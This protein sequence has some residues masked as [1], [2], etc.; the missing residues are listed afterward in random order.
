M[1]IT[2]KRIINKTKKQEITEKIQMTNECMEKRSQPQRHFGK[3]IFKHNKIFSPL[4]WQK[5][6]SSLISRF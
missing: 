5:L 4:N 2:P 1:F 3:C 6:N